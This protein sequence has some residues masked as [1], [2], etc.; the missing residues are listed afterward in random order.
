[1]NVNSLAISATSVLLSWSP[2]SKNDTSCPPTAYT[3]TITA[4]N[5]SLDPVVINITNSTTNKTVSGLTQ[6][7]E[8]SFTVAGVDAGGR[9][10]ENSTPSTIIMKSWLLVALVY[11]YHKYF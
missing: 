3:I 5:S 1:M 11:A 10:G 7:L 4:A 2:P 9:V 8:Y 6:G